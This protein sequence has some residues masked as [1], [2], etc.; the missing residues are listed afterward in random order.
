MGSWP[1]FG[2]LSPPPHIPAEHWE[3][4]PDTAALAALQDQGDP[5]N[6]GPPPPEASTSEE[7]EEE[8][9]DSGEEA[10]PGEAPPPA[11][12]AANPFA[13]LAEDEC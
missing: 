4:H 8:E 10:G 3:Q 5:E 2:V 9:G 6:R 13:L 1:L 11:S 7:E 12:T